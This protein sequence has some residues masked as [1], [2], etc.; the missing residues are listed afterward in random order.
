MFDAQ[1]ALQEYKQL[2]KELQVAKVSQMLAKIQELSDIFVKLKQRV[3]ERGTSIDDSVLEYIYRLLLALMDRHQ[4]RK[5]DKAQWDL[6]V[7]QQT[8]QHI[9]SLTDEDT[10]DIESQL[11]NL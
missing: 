3:D 9:A 4:Q 5:Q 11:R 10:E 7:Q 1:K 2:S 8:L 6:L